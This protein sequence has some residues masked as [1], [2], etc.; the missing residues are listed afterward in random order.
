MEQQEC[1]N[2]QTTGVP[3]AYKAW[4]YA[5]A[6]GKSVGV[7]QGVARALR[8]VLAARG[9]ALTVEQDARIA[10]CQDSAQ[11]SRWLVAAATATAGAQVFGDRGAG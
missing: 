1:A 9:L 5:E 6:H 4:Q 8:D 3:K 10:Q 2:P 11:L 7:A